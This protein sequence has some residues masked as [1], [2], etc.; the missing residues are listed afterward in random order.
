[1]WK[2]EDTNGAGASSHT[3]LAGDCPQTQSPSKVLRVWLLGA[4]GIGAGLRLAPRHMEA[5]LISA[6]RVLDG[7]MVSGRDN[8][9]QMGLSTH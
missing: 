1:M 8:S 5:A 7:W 2:G 9:P 3:G 6:G 4:S